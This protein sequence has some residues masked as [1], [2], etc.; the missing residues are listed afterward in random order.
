MV[1]RQIRQN[2]L[3]M[4]Y[5]AKSGHPGGSL[6]SV[7]LLKVLFVDKVLNYKII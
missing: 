3:K 4:I 7:E 2:I 5:N 1:C 6:S